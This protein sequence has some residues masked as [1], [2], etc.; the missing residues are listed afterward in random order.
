MQ[1]FAILGIQRTGTTL[2][3]TTLD[4]HP[5]IMCLGEIF[6]MR[7]GMAHGQAPRRGF[8]TRTDLGYQSYIQQSALRR[9]RNRIA[10]NSMVR[11]Y[12]DNI[13][14]SPGYAAIGFKFMYSQLR[15]Y[16]SVL[17]YIR[18]KNIRVIHVVRENVLKTHLSKLTMRA[19]GLAHSTRKANL[20]SV[21]V[22]TNDLIKTLNKI[23]DNGMRWKQALDGHSEYMQITYESFVE[24]NASVLSEVLAFL[25]VDPNVSLQSDLVQLNTAPLHEII[26]N[27]DEVQ[28]CLA[29]TP[30]SWCI[31]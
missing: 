24:D 27:F 25:E 20:V 16:P 15:K 26:E 10:R 18:T 14:Q 13:Y 8:K 1:K 31:D 29:D 9:L 11:E 17:Q 12:L 21:R 19:R 7:S 22:P 6:Q 2:V 4:S 5:D 30:F 28:D 23:Q 3:R